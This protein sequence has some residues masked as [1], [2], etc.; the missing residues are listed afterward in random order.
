MG[1]RM[2]VLAIGHISYDINI[3]I[4]NMPVENEKYKVTNNVNCGGGSVANAACLL[5]KWGIE[6][7]MAGVIG[8]DNYGK[9]IIQEFKMA[10]VKTD[11]IE[12]NYENDT[13]LSF[14]LINQN[15]GNKTIYSL[16]KDNLFLKKHDFQYAPDIIVVDGYDFNAA[17]AAFNKYPNAIKIMNANYFNEATIKLSKYTNYVICSKN[18]AENLAKIKFDINNQTTY[19]KIYQYLKDYYKGDIIITLGENGVLY[20]LNNQ[21]KLLPSYK[22]KVLDTT[23]AKDIFLGA[24][25]YAISTSK[26]KE[27]A[28]KL[29]NIAAG[30]S[31]EIMGGRLSIPDLIKVTSIFN[32]S[33]NQ[34]SANQPILNTNINQMQQNTVQSSQNQVINNEQNNQTKN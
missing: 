23:G 1:E 3:P 27:D 31:V 12:T 15:T 34:V 19:A 6:T 7:Y 30:L 20:S 17:I 8:N 4:T 24:F 33:N 21:I 22:T 2:R 5:G 16:I 25:A 14:I 32:P 18:F 10:N 29:A 26:T 11:L 9:N 28:I 13:S